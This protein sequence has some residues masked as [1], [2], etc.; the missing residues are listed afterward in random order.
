MLRFLQPPNQGQGPEG[1]GIMA[2]LLSRVTKVTRKWEGK[3]F[4]YEGFY[5][6]EEAVKSRLRRSP[7][8]YDYFRQWKWIDGHG[9]LSFSYSFSPKAHWSQSRLDP[10][11]YLGV[12]KIEDIS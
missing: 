11:Q 1:G 9:R 8:A 7:H 12:I 4:T 5:E 2:Y 3:A 10:R 6:N